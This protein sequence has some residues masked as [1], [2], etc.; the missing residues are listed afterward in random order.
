MEQQ[1]KLAIEVSEGRRHG[2]TAAP[3]LIKKTSHQLAFQK[4]AALVHSLGPLD[5]RDECRHG[6]PTFGGPVKECTFVHAPC[7][8]G[9]GVAQAIRSEVNDGQ[10]NKYTMPLSADPGVADFGGCH[11]TMASGKKESEDI[12]TPTALREPRQRVG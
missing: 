7:Y 3:Q 4:I 8:C 12:D 6:E 10:P 9:A 5:A 2:A 11:E 1:L